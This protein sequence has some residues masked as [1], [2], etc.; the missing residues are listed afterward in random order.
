[1]FVDHR[2]ELVVYY[3]IVFRR[4]ELIPVISPILPYF[5]GYTSHFP[6]S[7]YVIMSSYSINWSDVNA[8]P[9]EALF[10][11]MVYSF[12]LDKP[13]NVLNDRPEEWVRKPS[14]VS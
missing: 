8:L 6:L 1:M 2:Y 12:F 14:F 13:V 10:I 11:R 4:V 9:Y 7:S 5:F 3:A